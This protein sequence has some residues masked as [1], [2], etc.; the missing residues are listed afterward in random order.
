MN[1]EINARMD[2]LLNDIIKDNRLGHV[3]Q[4]CVHDVETFRLKLV[5]IAELMKYETTRVE[6]GG[7]PDKNAYFTFARIF[8]RF[9]AQ[10]LELG[11]PADV[12]EEFNAI[13]NNVRK[14]AG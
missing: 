12:C 10:L 6:E 13:S 1:Q 3:G 2:A 5:A 7:T 9:S 4:L 8:D 14:S 11:A